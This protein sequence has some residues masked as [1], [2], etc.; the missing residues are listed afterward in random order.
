[1]SD[2]SILI[3][4]CGG[5][6]TILTFMR[7]QSTGGR[8]ATRGCK[9]FERSALF[10]SANVLSSAPPWRSYRAQ[11]LAHAA[12]QERADGGQLLPV[13]ACL[14][15]L[16]W[17]PEAESAGQRLARVGRLLGPEKA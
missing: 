8:A 7:P 15:P 17:K 6:A 14:L 9:S 1:M 16:E 13:S 11:L 10:M 3:T 12:Q 4:P 2:T 5:L